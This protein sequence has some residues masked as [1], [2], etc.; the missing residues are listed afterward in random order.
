MTPAYDKI[1]SLEKLSAGERG[2]FKKPLGSLPSI[3]VLF[4]NTYHIGASNLG[5]HYL[6]SEINQRDDLLA[7][8][9]FYDILPPLGMEGAHPLGEY[10]LILIT[11]PF[12]LDYPNALEMLSAAGIPPVRG[13]RSSCHPL[14]AAGGVAISMNPRPFFDFADLMFSGDGEIGLPVLLESFLRHNRSKEDMLRDLSV[15]KGFIVPEYLSPQ[16]ETILP[17]FADNLPSPP[18][19]SRFLTPDTEFSDT[20]LIEIS[21]GCPYGCA[22]CYVG[23]CCGPFRAHSFDEVKKCMER[24]REGTSRFGL[25]S[26][27]V[28]AHPDLE[29]ICRWCLDENLDVSFSSLRADHISPLVLELLRRSGQK[30]LTLAPETGNEGFR[31]EVLRKN[32]S[33]ESLETLVREAARLGFQTFKFY[34]MTGLPGEGIEEIRSSCD[35][36][37]RLRQILLEEGR[38][39]GRLPEIVVT[40]SLFSPRP[41]TPLGNAP[42]LSLMEMKKRQK[43]FADHLR[44]LPNVR[45]Q[46]SDPAEALA[47]GIIARGGPETGALLLEKSKGRL[48]W[49]AA[50]KRM[51]LS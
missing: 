9:F 17:V 4:P 34:F 37:G 40:L 23:H 47:Q 45:M 51:E 21:R 15:K 36:A 32:M 12:E 14:I 42:L 27:A 13:E 20:C 24:H 6:Y 1:R 30:T 7:H 38:A 33:N 50:L 49:K 5:V 11:I 22:F 31:R 39:M 41:G 10:D 43:V 46:A 44:P 29:K 3:A 18:I 48:S 19:S 26:S 2:A 28:G 25:V 35:L 16:G 8:R